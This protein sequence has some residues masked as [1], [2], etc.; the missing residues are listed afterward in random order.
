MIIGIGVFGKQVVRYKVPQPYNIVS[1]WPR[2][3]IAWKS[4][5]LYICHP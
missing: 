3:K 5:F 4:R 1:P 2:I